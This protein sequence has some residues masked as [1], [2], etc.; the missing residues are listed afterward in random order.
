M[1]DDMN[2]KILTYDLT[3]GVDG[4]DGVF[5]SFDVWVG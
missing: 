3:I 2:G 4:L 1:R 5:R